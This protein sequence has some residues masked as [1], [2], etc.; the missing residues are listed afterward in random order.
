[1]SRSLKD[2]YPDKYI[3]FKSSNKYKLR[4]NMQKE[5]KV[6]KEECLLNANNKCG[7]CGNIDSLDVH[8]IIPIDENGTNDQSNLICLCRKCHQQV[9]KN[10]YKINPNDKTITPVINEAHIIPEDTKPDYL[11]EFEES[12]GITLYKCTNSFYYFDEGIKTKIKASDIKS[13]MFSD[14]KEELIRLKQLKKTSV[15]ERKILEQY[16][17]MFKELGNKAMWHQ[18][19]HI[20]RIWD[21]LTDLQKNHVF[22][23]LHNTFGEA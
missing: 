5:F 8:H 21:T 13:I 1:M 15:K 2:L 6:A 16:K 7:L 17:L 12:T 9:H 23:T 19:I 22:D 20:I 4:N 10:V 14:K 3:E 11:K 18:I